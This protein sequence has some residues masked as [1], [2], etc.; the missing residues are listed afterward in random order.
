[1]AVAVE[2]GRRMKHLYKQIRFERWTSYLE[3]LPHGQSPSKSVLET[4]EI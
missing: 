3:Y 1:M 4:K 2:G